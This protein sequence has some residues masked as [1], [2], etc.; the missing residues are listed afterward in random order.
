MFMQHPDSEMFA[1][2]LT[3]S[4]VEILFS[5]LGWFRVSQV[6]QEIAS[7]R[8]HRV[9]S[10][11][12]AA[13][14][15]YLAAEGL[16]HDAASKM[17]DGE[18]FDWQEAYPKMATKLVAKIEDCDLGGKVFDYFGCAPSQAASDILLEAL[19]QR[20]NETPLSSMNL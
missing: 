12:F 17:Q 5:R 2:R 10:N 3:V 13:D 7:R 6:A 8:A 14:F 11:D 20:Y 18:R 19:C 15:V 9:A 4:C 1:K 16:L